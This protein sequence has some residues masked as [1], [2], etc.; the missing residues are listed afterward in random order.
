MSA[1]D[2]RITGPGFL[3]FH[4]RKAMLVYY[5][6]NHVQTFCRA[7]LN[8]S[9]RVYECNGV[10][11]KYDPAFLLNMPF[12]SD[13]PIK[14]NGVDT[15][16]HGS[17]RL[18]VELSKNRYKRIFVLHVKE[19]RILQYIEHVE[20]NFLINDQYQM[21]VLLFDNEG[22]IPPVKPKEPSNEMF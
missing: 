13:L 8:P 16:Q 3:K 10:L 9:S 6:I 20:L 15:T 21:Q 2:L 12:Q 11:H 14:L 19:D 17:F 7:M 18:S 1:F 4:I 22:H 5:S